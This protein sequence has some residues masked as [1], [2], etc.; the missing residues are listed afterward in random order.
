[1]KVA[2]A[3]GGEFPLGWTDADDLGE[4]SVDDV[5]CV[6]GVHFLGRGGEA[7]QWRS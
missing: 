1:M 4:L 6:P 3:L 7:R 5:E 2:A